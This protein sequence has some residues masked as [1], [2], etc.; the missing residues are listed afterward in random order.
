MGT[1]E[2][3]DRVSGLSLQSHLYK[4]LVKRLLRRLIHS[5]Y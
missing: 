3:A 4:I 2:G 1:H 5:E